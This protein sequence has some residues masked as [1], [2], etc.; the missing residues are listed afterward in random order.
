MA[1]RRFKILYV[2]HSISLLDSAPVKKGVFGG[3][4]S[5]KWVSFFVDAQESEL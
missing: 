2:A 5:G 3:R 1:T 4:A